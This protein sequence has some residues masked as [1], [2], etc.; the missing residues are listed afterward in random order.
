MTT[1]FRKL[2]EKLT[3]LEQGPDCPESVIQVLADHAEKDMLSAARVQWAED[4]PAPLEKPKP[5]DAPDGEEDPMLD[6]KKNPLFKE[7]AKD[8]DPNLSEKT[9]PLFVGGTA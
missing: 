7:D 9:N 3:R 5:D 6:P 2:A 1:A 8:E 4:H